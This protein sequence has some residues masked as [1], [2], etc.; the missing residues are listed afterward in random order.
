MFMFFPFA[1]RY[2][3]MGP[4]TNAIVTVKKFVEWVCLVSNSVLVNVFWTVCIWLSNY[5]RL[6][7][8]H[9]GFMVPVLGEERSGVFPPNLSL[10]FPGQ[11]QEL[12]KGL[13]SPQMLK[14]PYS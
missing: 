11:P 6:R 3:N 10:T 1:D 12:L 2:L 4:K 7:R 9:W 8:W 5:H 14:I 13:N